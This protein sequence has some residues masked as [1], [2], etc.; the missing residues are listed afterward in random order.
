ME[1][2]EWSAK[3]RKVLFAAAL[4]AALL[5]IAA[6][7]V[8]VGVP[9]VRFA[10]E[11]E[12]FR[13]WVDARGIWGR[14]AYIGM[15]LF[16]ILI[17]LIPGEP[18]EIVGGYAFGA[19][20]GTL[21]CLAASTAGSILV[22]LLVRRFGMRLVGVF[23]SRDKLNSL[24]FLRSTPKRDFL[25]LLIFMLPGTP[26]DLLSY[27]A[28]LTD[29]RFPVWLLICSFGRI[30]SI[31]TSIVGGDALG[32]GNYTYAILVFAVTLAVSGVGLFVYNQICLKHAG[33][34]KKED[35]KDPSKE[36]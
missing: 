1:K 23:F 36:N 27:F 16:Q 9:L 12:H 24:R 34:T 22:F 8:L 30:P 13:D 6:L 3:K 7:G 11:P 35:T 21:L 25:F 33:K 18:F 10:S 19:V 4:I 29:I 26:K 28:G 5:L 17:A 20:E 2:Q 31:I 14:L 15:V 32:E